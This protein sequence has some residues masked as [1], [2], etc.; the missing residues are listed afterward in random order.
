MAV[1][2]HGDVYI[3]EATAQRVQRSGRVRTAVTVAGTGTAGFNGDGLAATASEL[4]QPTGV[5]VDA[6]GD[7]FIADTANCRVAGAARGDTTLFGQAV[8]AGHLYTVAGTG[9]CGS[10]GQGGPRRRPSS[11]I[12]WPSPS[13]PRRP[14][15][16]RQR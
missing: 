13:T 12:R 2:A 11:G 5:A 15:G 4:D 1:D 3:A 10:A 8:M 16:G 14:P 6:A 9:V 7:L